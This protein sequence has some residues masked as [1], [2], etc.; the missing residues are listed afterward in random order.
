MPAERIDILSAVSIIFYLFRVKIQF[1]FFSLDGPVESD[2]ASAEEKIR[3]QHPVY[4]S[5]T[6]IKKLRPSILIT[7]LFRFIRQN[8]VL[9]T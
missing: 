8:Q 1:T 2:A 4:I 7:S 5:Y 9:R 6:L 3:S